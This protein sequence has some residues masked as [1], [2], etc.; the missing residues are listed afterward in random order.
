MYGCAPAHQRT[1]PSIDQSLTKAHG[2]SH[3]PKS[4]AQSTQKRH[5]IPDLSGS[6]SLDFPICQ[7]SQ[8]FLFSGLAIEI[9][10]AKKGGLLTRQADKAEQDW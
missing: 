2:K 8:H 7:L 6:E 10:A 3:T 5:K 1:N 9:A 4:P